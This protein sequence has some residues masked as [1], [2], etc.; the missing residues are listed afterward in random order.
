MMALLIIWL[1]KAS[2]KSRD[3][4]WHATLSVTSLA[5]EQ[6]HSHDMWPVQSGGYHAP[7]VLACLAAASRQYPVVPGLDALQL[8]G[9]HRHICKLHEASIP[10]TL[11]WVGVAP[12]GR[13]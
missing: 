1:L 12:E 8:P 5:R 2:A 4:L 13:A 6:L 11:L 9:G 7:Q 10:I 3:S